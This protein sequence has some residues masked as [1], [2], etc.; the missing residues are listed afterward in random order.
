M[1]YS[2]QPSRASEQNVVGYACRVTNTEPVLD[3]G[4]KRR[5]CHRLNGVS[6]HIP[7]IVGYDELI[8]LFA[9]YTTVNYSRF[10]SETTD[11]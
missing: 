5:H 10:C 9:I 2:L 8:D 4:C 7:E 11:I 6:Q 1:N 3:K